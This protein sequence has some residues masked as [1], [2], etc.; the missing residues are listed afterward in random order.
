MK[1][2]LVPLDGS[3]LAEQVLPY[4]R[5]LAPLM[6]AGVRLLTVI[7]DAY[8]EGLLTE[9]LAAAYGV[10]DPLTVQRERE[11][12]ESLMHRQHAESY[13]A[14]QAAPL[15]GHGLDV[16]IDV[17]YG[18]AAEVIVEVAEGH[19]V[20][21][22]AMA[23][24]GYSGL[25][26]WALGSVTDKVAHATTRPMFVVRGAAHAPEGAAAF[27]RVMVPLDGSPF[28][29]QALPCAAEL[30]AQSNAELLLMQ[31]VMPTIESY[32]RIAPLGRPEVL[33]GDV[34]AAL[35]A[36]ATADLERQASELRRRG[37]H[38]ATHVVDGPAAESIV[39]EARHRAVDLVVMATHGY[40]GLKRWA[41]GS[42]ADK[43]LHA[44]T[45]PLILVRAQEHAKGEDPDL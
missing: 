26:R 18:P 43:V 27:Q 16:E 8:G 37:L 29:E 30:A 6:G 24:H 21:L 23:T 28:A 10:T 4:I 5:T 7:S 2:I 20:A 9:S 19:H 15:E 33:P 38:V 39:D 41:L 40:S 34:L 44:A 32:P 3:A 22:I 14:G 1:T 25:K 45:T 17:R 11:R 31:A 35:R 42:V 12:R 13:L 36:Q